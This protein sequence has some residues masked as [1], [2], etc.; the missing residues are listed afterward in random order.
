MPGFFILHRSICFVA[1]CFPTTG[2]GIRLR[3]SSRLAV[4]NRRDFLLS[5]AAVPALTSGLRLD[6][7]H[8][9]KI[10]SAEE[11][12]PVGNYTPYGYLDNPFH[13]W[14]LHRSGVIRST[15]GIGFGFFYPAGPGGYFEFAKSEI[16]EAHLRLGLLIAGRRR[17]LREDFACDQLSSSYHSKN[18]FTYVFEDTGV[19]LDCTF[20]QVGEHA[21]A[22]YIA[23][24][25]TTRQSIRLLAVAE[26]KLGPAVWWGRDGLAGEYNPDDDAV[27]IQSF[28]AG[29]AFTL[30]ADSASARHF[31]GENSSDLH[32][33][34]E[35]TG[36]REQGLSYYPQPLFGAL[37]FKLEV[38]PGKTTERAVTLAR[39]EH[40]TLSTA[41]AR[42][43]LAGMRE[44]FSRKYSEDAAFWSAA[45]RLEDDWPRH[46][47]NGWV[48]DFETLRMIVRR[49]LG[50]YKHPWDGMQIQAPRTVLA[51]TSIDMWA[52]SYADAHLAKE[53]FLGLFLNSARDNVP[54]SREDGEMNMVA[55]DG[56][57]CGTSISWCYPYFC[58]RSIWRRTRDKRWLGAIYP[59]LVR[60]LRWTLEHR[61]DKD[62]FVIAK[63]SWESGMDAASRFLIP[64]P[65]GGELIEFLRLVELQAA[66]AQAAQIL[67]QFA[68]SLEDQ[69][70]IENWTKIHTL[71]RA[72]AQSLWKDGWF[73][74][75]NTESGQLVT[76]TGQHVGQ[77]APIFCGLTD[78]SQ[79]ESM[80]PALHRFFVQSQQP[81][82]ESAEDWQQPLHW[83]SLVLP[84]LESLAHAKEMEL[85]SQ[86]VEDIAERIYTMT[87]RRSLAAVAG[88]E[89]QPRTDLKQRLGWPGVSCEIWGGQGAYGGEGY[90]W[91]AVLPAHIIR[92]VIG[93]RD[94]ETPNELRLVP[95]LPERFMVT[96]K[97]YRVRNLGYAG[98]KLAL[99]L[100]PLD[101]QRLLL[102]GAWARSAK[103]IAVREAMGAKLSFEGSGSTWQFEA[104]N[105]KAYVLRITDLPL[106]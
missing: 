23:A 82:P 71:Y 28:A 46:W 68:E 66:M 56:S 37:E 40:R 87:D 100:R 11:G 101:S 70:E 27:R 57:E 10:V 32:S 59:G 74:D 76:H 89:R 26:C 55:T 7:R 4:Y 98:E 96:G 6:L 69:P 88:G 35:G 1:R 19:Q 42:E 5:L 2:F 45:P 92:H 81:Q 18:L 44:E 63:C 21:L 104:S 17:W 58:A 65:T 60:L 84:Y 24:Q 97:R 9:D 43:S 77:V 22:A 3:R 25:G 14:N 95:N 33:W 29:P 34:F 78:A 50:M 80:G 91:G 16:Y 102:E 90:G 47:K 39:G 105:R 13:S 12:F 61:T 99:A 15:P 36:S 83:S 49:P 73:Y 53:V 51:E 52:L 54:C 79:T 85:L 64:Q 38:I 94:P 86:V 62:K 8:G 75:W 48:Y 67:S 103:T 20:L 41:R 93:F 72:K 106:T 31:L 30:R